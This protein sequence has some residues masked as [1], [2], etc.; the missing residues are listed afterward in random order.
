MTTKFCTH[1]TH[2]GIC[3]R[4]ETFCNPACPYEEIKELAPVVHGRWEEMDLCD[5][6]GDEIMRLPKGAVRCSACANAFE[7][8]LLWK[9]NF[10]PNC[11]ARMDGE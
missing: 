9:K 10:C 4:T 2:G 11:G 3:E 7:K 1:E 5:L 6:A 8:S